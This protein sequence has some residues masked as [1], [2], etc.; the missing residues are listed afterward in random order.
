MI[1]L[2][3]NGSESLM[4]VLNPTDKSRSVNIGETLAA[5]GLEDLR[6]ASDGELYVPE[7]LLSS[8]RYTLR[9][10]KGQKLSI[11]P[12]SAVVIRL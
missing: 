5:A 10:Q 6:S 12:A 8:G 11:G 2:R 1:Y 4:V 9:V 7:V 3:S